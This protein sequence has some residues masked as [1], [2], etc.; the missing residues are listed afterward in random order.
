MSFSH[1]THYLK[2]RCHVVMSNR[3]QLTDVAYRKFILQ[4]HKNIRGFQ[5]KQGL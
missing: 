4:A 3:V 5:A 2:Q 1:L